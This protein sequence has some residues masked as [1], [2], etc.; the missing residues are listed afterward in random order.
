MSIMNVGG[1][2]FLFPNCEL[3]GL[4]NSVYLIDINEEQLIFN[5]S[6]MSVITEDIFFCVGDNKSNLFRKT[7]TE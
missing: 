6:F 5:Q 3:N 1:I 7:E 2:Y 4:L